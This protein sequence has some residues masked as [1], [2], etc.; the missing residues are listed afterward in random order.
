MQKV[1]KI[2]AAGDRPGADQAAGEVL[3][4]EPAAVLDVLAEDSGLAFDGEPS[5][6]LA[7]DFLASGLLP[8]DVLALARLSVA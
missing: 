4:D 5:V 1:V 6:P 7:S 8:A 3:F 2:V